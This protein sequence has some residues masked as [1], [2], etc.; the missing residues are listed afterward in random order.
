MKNF[1]HVS[2]LTRHKEENLAFYTDLLGLRFVKNTINQENHR[3]LHY[4]YGDYQGSPGSVI[5][6]FVVPKLGNRYDNDHYLSTIGWNLPQ[7]S[8][9]FWVSR[10]KQSG[11]VADRQDNTLTFPDPD[12]VALVFVETDL[13]PIQEEFS[14]ESNIPADKQLLGLRSIDFHV[15]QPQ[16]TIDFFHQFLDWPTV[17]DTLT[18][19]EQAYVRILPSNST[20]PTHM[21]R[22]SIDHVAFA[23]KDEEA[24]HQLHQKALNEQWQVE[25]LVSRGY[26]KSLYLREPG[27]NRVEFATLGP[28]FT[29]DEDIDH[30]GETLALPPFLAKQR[31]EIE[32]HLYPEK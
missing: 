18:L 23:V 6:F 26:F 3:M 14:V 10:L 16:K 4:Y 31:K 12:G 15:A 8:L 2:L 13:E 19:N 1:H 9:D 29:I 21:G 24:L 22:G 28:G 7:G 25:Q 20:R 27:G 30:L 17:D 11:I 5:T 32:A